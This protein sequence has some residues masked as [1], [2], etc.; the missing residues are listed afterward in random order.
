M[1]AAIFVLV[2]VVLIVAGLIY[3]GLSNDR[4]EDPDGLT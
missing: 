3:V 2:V 4:P 1:T